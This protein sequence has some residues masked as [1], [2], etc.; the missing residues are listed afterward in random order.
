M[1]RF[2]GASFTNYTS[3]NSGLPENALNS[4]VYDEARDR[5]WIG[6]VFEG[7]CY[8][9]HRSGKIER[10]M[11]SKS[12][13]IDNVVD[14]QIATDDGIWVVPHYGEVSHYD[15]DSD[16]WTSLKD[17]A[18]DL[19]H[20]SNWS[21]YDDNMGNLYVGHAQGGISII[22]LKDKEVTHLK[23]TLGAPSSLP[24][25]SVYAFCKDPMG[26]LWVG[27]D[28]GLGLFNAD[29]RSFRAFK[30]DDQRLTSLIADHIYDIK[31]IGDNDLW[32]AADVG[33]VSILDIDK[34]PLV[35]PEK[36]EFINLF[37]NN[38]ANGLSSNNARTVLQDSFG[39]I[40]IGNYSSGL[41]FIS[42]RSYVFDALPYVDNSGDA[43]A[44]K[45][46]WSVYN[47]SNGNLW[48]G[49]QSELVLFADGQVEKI[50]DISPYLTRSQGQIFSLAG[51]DNGEIYLGLYDD[52]LLKYD[53]SSDK[54]TRL[55]LG[56]GNIDV[57]SL[58]NDIDGKLLIGTEYG[59]YS[60]QNGAVKK[61]DAINRMLPD[62]SVYGIV[63][64][65]QG[66]LWIGTYA[67]GIMVLDE[68][69]QTADR[70]GQ[71][72][73]LSVNDLIMDSGGAIWAA[74]RHGLAYIKDTNNPNDI[75]LYD[76]DEGLADDF[77]RSVVEDAQGKIWVSGNNSISCWNKAT[78]SFENYG[79]KNG[80]PNGNFIEGGAC[81]DQLGNLYFAS[82]AGVCAFNP[83][84]ISNQAE[85]CGIEI[86]ECRELTNAHN[87]PIAI[88]DNAIVLPYDQN[89]LRLSF[90]VPDYSLRGQVEYAYMMPGVTDTWTILQNDNK[91]TFY[92]LPPDDYEFQAKARL[93]NQSWE[94]ASVVSLKVRINPPFWWTW[95]AKL[96]YAI[97]FV[98][99]IVACVKVYLHRVNLKNSLQL[100]EDKNRI[101]QELN[102]ERLRFYTNITHELRTPLTL[103]LGPLEDLANDPKLPAALEPKTKM[104]YSSAQ[105]LLGLVN[106]L[107]EFRKTETQNRRLS[108]A[109]GNLCDLV[110]ETGLRFKELNTNKD[111][112]FNLKV[113]HNLP[114][115]Y[116]DS[117]VVTTISNN[118]LSNAMKYTPAG[119]ISMS[120]E[121]VTVEGVDYAEIKV[122]DTGYGIEA[123]ALAHIFDRYYQ[124]DG[125]HQASGTGIGLALVKSLTELH[126]GR[127]SVDSKPNQ[128]STF[129]VMLPL[130]ES[131]PEALHKD[132]K[133]RPRVEPET[134]PNDNRPIIL[135]V[136]DNDDIREYVASSLSSDYRVLTAKNGKVGLS[137]ALRHIPDV[138]ISDIMMPEMDGI[139]MCKAVKAD[140]AT[141]H[142]PV[143][144]LTAKD[145]L[146]DKEE[147]YES[148]ADSYLTKP[149]SAKL[150]RSRVTNLLESR[151]KLAQWIAD[152]AKSNPA[153]EDSPIETQTVPGLNP[154]DAAFL[155]KLNKV[156]EDNISD[157]E[158]DLGFI[159]SQMCMSQSTLYRKIKGLTG[160]SGNKLIR[161]I[162]L[163][164]AIHLMQHCNHNISEAAYACGFNDVDYFRSCFKD[165]YGLPPTQYL[166]ETALQ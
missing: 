47:D 132:N 166:K 51:N 52:G 135:V 83:S 59:I 102:N 56:G 151:K 119:S 12:M 87:G 138:I 42:H 86:I 72:T 37:S 73:N 160:M 145:S 116:F 35:D 162:R 26:N 108:V 149:F 2:D 158:L 28:Q 141:S 131:Y 10:V 130:D 112:D 36:V 157:G 123:D 74:T 159:S 69:L 124:A 23:H 134:A 136:E 64:D 90:S 81:R 19:D 44:L 43:P 115:M 125:K 18:I 140:V 32:I 97:L 33:G 126:H 142:I 75:A 63:R 27:T 100:S 7:L 45:P 143:V 113:D 68:K 106:Q 3:L 79:L 80:L 77:V 22:N 129:K 55:S 78:S 11:P 99:L 114:L 53:T 127:I 5:V 118:L 156:I 122:K 133:A 84:N 144:L 105:R 34:Q 60:Y 164:H 163:K 9:D 58:Y 155:E 54:I 109:K 96:F 30:H 41:D 101:E 40:W 161:K 121:K 61:E 29:S 82:L 85:K 31:V 104:I 49:G 50:V 70:L 21:C 20:K 62:Q 92:N 150:L 107:L 147:G 13:A 15:P 165:E 46:S 16:K 146:N 98:L 154:L 24:G 67:G 65:K 152:H 94:E 117:E 71:D 17:L 89:S 110:T 6:G 148:G 88:N 120:L 111:V 48:I 93:N 103:I 128:G 95:Y 8:Y 38:T 57:I 4:L 137:E 153:N 25:N 1:S 76:H 66:K 91:A 14:I 39:N 139:E